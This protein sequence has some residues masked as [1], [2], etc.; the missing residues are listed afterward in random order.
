MTEVIMCPWKALTSPQ[1]IEIIVI[2][3]NMNLM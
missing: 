1:T 2:Y 3:E